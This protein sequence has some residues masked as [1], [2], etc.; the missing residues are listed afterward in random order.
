MHFLEQFV[1]AITGKDVL[2]AAVS[3][4]AAEDFSTEMSY[5]ARPRM[6][7]REFEFIQLLPEKSSCRSS[8]SFAFEFEFSRVNGVLQALEINQN[9][10]YKLIYPKNTDNYVQ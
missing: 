8:S 3:T 6:I 2:S 10:I 1:R 9:S 4:A 7:Y 5:T